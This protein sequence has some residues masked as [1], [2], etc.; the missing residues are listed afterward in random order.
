MTKTIEA[1][2]DGAAFRPDTPPELAQGTRWRLTVQSLPDT[3][4]RSVWSLLADAAGS[5]DAP[6]DWAAEHDHYLS[7]SPKREPQP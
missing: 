7:G 5:I 3:G 2:F 4:E 1:T 6:A